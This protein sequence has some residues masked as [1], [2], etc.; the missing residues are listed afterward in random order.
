MS[1]S[2]RVAIQVP[3]TG[4]GERGR[5]ASVLA[6]LEA[7]FPGYPRRHLYVLMGVGAV[8]AA[9]RTILATVFEDVRRAFDVSDAQLGLLTAAYSVVATLSVIPFGWLA[10]SW[11]RVRLIALGFLPWSISMIWTGAS[12]S[13]AMMFAARI[14]LGTIE[15]TNGPS[16][17]SLIGDYYPVHE[18]GRVMG[19]FRVG[20]LIGSLLGFA[21]GGLL[22]TLFGWRWAFFVWGSFGFLC[23]GLVLRLLP[24]PARG[25]PDAIHRVKQKLADLTARADGDM[26][27]APAPAEP[28][29][30]EPGYDYR[31]LTVKQATV[32]IAKV[33][34]MWLVFIAAAISEF[35]MSGLGTWAPTFFRRYH[36]FSAVGA[37]GIVALLALSVVAGTIVGARASDRM[38]SRGQPTQRIRMCAFASVLSFGAMAVAFGLDR[39]ALVVPFFLMSGF[40]IGVPFAALDA[41]ALDILV[42]HLRGRA[43]AVRSLLRIAGVAAAPLLFGVLSDLYGLRS[44]LLFT[45]PAVLLAGAITLLA[46]KTYEADMEFAQAE[47][48]RQHELED[49]DDETVEEVLDEVLEKVADL[50]TAPDPQ[51]RGP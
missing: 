20:T 12:T 28:R 40:L 16:T 21:V 19:I 5:L 27:P 44:A 3:A 15:A 29:R 7:R 50:P 34:T 39:F 8:D 23:G 1:E 26:A 17:P 30:P 51:R 32:E 46:V 35:F 33:R 45:M 49:A 24:E 4:E 37:G 18:R 9:D 31:S 38:L 41:V 48:V 6:G 22:A 36:G 47:A 10:D 2:P 42:P 13:F 14:F 43:S 11:N 25:L